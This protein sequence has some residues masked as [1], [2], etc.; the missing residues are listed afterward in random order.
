MD[1]QLHEHLN[2]VTREGNN[3]L[4][5][6]GITGEDGIINN[7]VRWENSKEGLYRMFK[8]LPTWDDEE[9]RFHVE[10]VK[11]VKPDHSMV[12]QLTTRLINS[13]LSYAEGSNLSGG[14]IYS[15]MYNA[16]VGISFLDDTFTIN[17][18]CMSWFN[19]EYLKLREGM[20]L[21]RAVTRAL[22][23]LDYGSSKLYVDR[24][25][26][27]YNNEVGEYMQSKI[28]REKWYVSINP[29]DYLSMS[30]GNGWRSCHWIEDGCYRAGC[31]SYMNDDT[32]VIIYKES[33]EGRTVK[34]ERFCGWVTADTFGIITKS[35]P[36]GYNEETTNKLL[37]S[38]RNFFPGM[39]NDG[40]VRVRSNS[41]SRV[42]PDYQHYKVFCISKLDEPT[43]IQVGGYAYSIDEDEV[44]ED[45][46][47]LSNGTPV[48]C[49]DCGVRIYDDEAQVLIDGEF[50]CMSCMTYCNICNEYCREAE[51]IEYY[52]IGHRGRRIIG[53]ACPHCYDHIVVC[54]VCGDA[55]HM[56][57]VVFLDEDTATDDRPEGYY[58]PDCI[59]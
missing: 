42:Y 51:A 41:G 52:M 50:Y 40:I 15:I 58:C 53:Y 16:E 39:C 10:T 55:W 27:D 57:Y 20:K 47:Y 6:L 28:I 3:Y 29:I 13:C 24:W 43:T 36:T 8:G 12:Q 23:R 45:E 54:D 30:D 19:S 46:G 5:R 26:R 34:Q 4:Y 14:D 11:E 35:Y 21:N 38:L 48:Y 31:F 18:S 37:T 9:L 32:T 59:E 25:I 56:D 22:Q 44:I 7:T 49:A 33:D 17:E 1:R 2:R